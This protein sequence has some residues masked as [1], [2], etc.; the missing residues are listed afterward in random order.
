M[1]SMKRNLKDGP[2]VVDNLKVYFVKAFNVEGLIFDNGSGVNK[3]S[4]DVD[5]N[6][7]IQGLL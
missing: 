6:G 3:R 1:R 5:S 4:L 7:R 2:R